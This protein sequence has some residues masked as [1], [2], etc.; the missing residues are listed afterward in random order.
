MLNS[1]VDAS[2]RMIA[3][4]GQERKVIFTVVKKHLLGTLRLQGLPQSARIPPGVSHLQLHSTP[5]VKPTMFFKT[6]PL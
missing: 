2:S 1:T 5:T 4:R 3:F 6:A